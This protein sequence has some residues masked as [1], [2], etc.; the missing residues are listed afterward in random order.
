MKKCK[1][2]GGY[3]E[4]EYEVCPY[5]G[6]YDTEKIDETETVEVT[7]LIGGDYVKRIIKK[8]KVKKIIICASILLIFFC[9]VLIYNYINMKEKKT[10]ASNELLYVPDVVG[11]NVNEAVEIL[12]ETGLTVTTVYKKDNEEKHGIVGS[13]SVISGM[14]VNK[15]YDVIIT[16]T[17]EH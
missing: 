11:L 5:C 16:I 13:Q 3:F 14:Y 6:N 1:K 10:A 9:S 17:A 12:K 4:E 2:C 8:R 7:S 15:G